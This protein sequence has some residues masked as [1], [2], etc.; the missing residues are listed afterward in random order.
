MSMTA[1]VPFSLRIDTE[2]KKQLEAEAKKANCSVSAVAVSAIKNHLLARQQK[3]DA[4]D[5]A[6]IEADKGAFISQKAMKHWVNAWDNTN[7]DTLPKV[8]IT[9]P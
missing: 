2:I 9:K 6:L 8:D 5:A 3:R 1:S 7:D 4:I